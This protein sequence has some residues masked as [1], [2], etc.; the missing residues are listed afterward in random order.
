VLLAYFALDDLPALLDA[1]RRSGLH[2]STVLYVGSYGFNAGAAS[3]IHESGARYAPMLALA[4]VAP[5]ADALAAMTTAERVAAGADTGRRFRDRSP[6]EAWQLDEL[7]AA[8][9]RSRPLREFARGLL[10]GLAHDGVRGWVWLSRG[11]FGLA[12]QP[13]DAEHQAFW[14]A[15]DPATLFLV[16]EEYPPFEDDPAAAARAQDAGRAALARGG[17]IRRSLA[18]RYAAGI[19]PGYHLAPGLGG[20]VHHRSRAAVNRWRDAYLAARRAAGVSTFAVFDFRFANA[21]PQV[22]RDICRA[23]SSGT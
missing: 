6:T 23:L 7:S 5:R 20:N 9:A 12:A 13:I 14:E 22:M 8:T 17:P 1:A 3:L 19:T 18:R 21:S 2:E 4:S 15:V 11:A 16:G 10:A